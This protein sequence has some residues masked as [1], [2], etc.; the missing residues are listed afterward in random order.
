M[1]RI[2][3]RD[4]KLFKDL[5]RFNG[6]S[7]PSIIQKTFNGSTHGYNRLSAFM[8]D[9]YID[10]TFYYALHHRKHKKS[11]T[12][13]ICAIYYLKPKGLRVIRKN[14]DP[15]YVRP[16][17]RKLDVHNLVSN[18]YMNIPNIL[19]RRETLRQYNLKPFMPVTCC[20]PSDPPIFIYVSGKDKNFAEDSRIAAFIESGITEAKHII[21]SRE[22]SEKFY[23]PFSYFVSWDS[24]PFIIP[25]IINDHHYYERQFVRVLKKYYP[26][27][28]A[29]F[30]EGLCTQFK[31]PDRGTY[32]TANLV[33]ASNLIRLNLQYPEKDILVSVPSLHHLYGINLKGGEFI[34][35]SEKDNKFY[36]MFAQSNKMKYKP[37]VA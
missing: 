27:A 36:R 14:I 1:P 12:Q 34:F 29:T 3:S 17:E 2:T 22:F 13:R 9:R 35:Y 8:K 28:S 7:G 20:I 25:N 19:S 11:F 31:I 6:L 24:A 26:T 23:K 4:I 18:F 30:T 32:K 10:Q 5:F 21:V 15:R 33:F 37:I 16:S